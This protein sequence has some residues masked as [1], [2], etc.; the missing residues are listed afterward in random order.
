MTNYKSKKK[1]FKKSR[2]LKKKGGSPVDCDKKLGEPPTLGEGSKHNS[3]GTI[4]NFPTDYLKFPNQIQ[5]KEKGT[6][7]GDSWK[8]LVYFLFYLSDSKVYVS[9]SWGD[10]ITALPGQLRKDWELCNKDKFIKNEIP[11][12][13]TGEIT[14][15][16]DNETI[17]KSRKNNFKFYKS[18]RIDL[19]TENEDKISLAFEK[20]DDYDKLIRWLEGNNIS[21]IKGGYINKKK[22]LKKK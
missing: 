18:N 6:I 9:Y 8:S 10:P 15:F 12:I 20:K 4:F 21:L 11:D 3:K 22:S 13:K 5:L 19:I 16:I 1:N 17:S 14:S 2:T 7:F